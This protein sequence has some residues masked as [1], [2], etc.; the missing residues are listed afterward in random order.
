MRRAVLLALLLLAPAFASA[1]SEP[2]LRVRFAPTGYGRGE[3]TLGVTS[4]GAI[5]A[6]ANVR[7]ADALT[8]EGTMV[9]SRDH[10]LTWEL[11][12]DP[13]EAKMDFDP[14]VW[15]D[16][17]TDRVFNSPLYVVCSWAT[18]SDDGG[19]SWSVNPVAGCGLPFHDH[20]KL[21]TGPPAAG[22]RTWGYP[23]VVYYSYDTL[24][25][26]GTWV[27]PSLDG[28]RTFLPGAAAHPFD[29]CQ[30]GV[31]SPVAVAPDGTAF[32]AKPTCTGVNVSVS[33][34][35]GASWSQAVRA[36]QAGIAAHLVTLDVATD[37][38]GN[39]YVAY[40]GSD[41]AVWLLASPD[42]GLTWRA[43]VKVSPPDAQTTVYAALAAG[44]RGRI[45]IAY[46]G[47]NATWPG[48]DPSF[49]PDSTTWNLYLTLVLDADAA[50]PTPQTTRLTSDADPVQRGCVWLQ[51]G[52][53]P[54]RNLREFLD[55]TQRA[56]RVYVSYPDGCHACVTASDRVDPAETV[57]V[58]EEEGPSLDG[59]VL[60]PLQ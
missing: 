8:V 45:A 4:D 47:T 49:A 23:S 30:N 36:D 31:A 33:R 48:G 3:P 40:Q 52:S 7:H 60:E 43:P 44:D 56:G 16:P 24:R 2:V 14:W 13:L 11:L 41:G 19:D 59:D 51:G 38:D 35:S 18:W 15:V 12:R 10:G 27:S 17:R 9:R 34:D 42:G 25:G 6:A 29:A 46:L 50:A 20:Q 22:V 28:G 55:V 58:I 32:S 5:F 57:V 54:C 21:T 53:N 26:E 1:A 39:P 37:E